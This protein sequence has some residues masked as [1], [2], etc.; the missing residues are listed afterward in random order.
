MTGIGPVWGG[1]ALGGDGRAAVRLA[2][3]RAFIHL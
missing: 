3:R 1:S 2:V